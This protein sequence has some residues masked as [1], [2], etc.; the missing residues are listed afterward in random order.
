VTSSKPQVGVDIEIWTCNPPCPPALK[1]ARTRR[2]KQSHATLSER[3]ESEREGRHFHSMTIPMVDP[4]RSKDGRRQRARWCFIVDHVAKSER[5]AEEKSR[6]CQRRP[7]ILDKQRSL[8]TSSSSF[9]LITT[10]RYDSMRCNMIVSVY[11]TTFPS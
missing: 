11:L 7:T 8:P 1:V 3:E 5:R 10:M 9:M 6:L 4:R 2:S